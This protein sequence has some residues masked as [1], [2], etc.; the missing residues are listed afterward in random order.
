MTADERNLC[1]GCAFCFL[2]SE[3]KKHSQAITKD[4]SAT[5]T[6]QIGVRDGGR[7]TPQ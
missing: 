3:K 4:R 7:T 5:Q 2:W 6:K 1:S